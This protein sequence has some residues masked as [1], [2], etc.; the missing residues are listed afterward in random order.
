MRLAL[1]LAMVL[2]AMPGT[3][4][5]QPAPAL[6][7]YKTAGSAAC[8]DD[9]TVWVDPETRLYYVKGDPG[10]GKTRRG[11]YNCRKHA[12]PGPVS[13]TISYTTEAVTLTI[14]DRGPLRADRPDTT[15][16]G[17]AGMTERV[18]VFGGTLDAGPCGPAGWLVRARLPLSAEA[19]R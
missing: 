14:E 3:A 12:E 6:T 13:V 10:F 7:L 11:G 1:A 9:A 16:Y 5:A 8:M 4:L 17:L 15:G 19:A 18:T 2:A